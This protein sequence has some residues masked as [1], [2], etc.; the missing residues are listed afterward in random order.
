MFAALERV[1]KYLIRNY[2]LVLQWQSTNFE[3]ELYELKYSF[4]KGTLE[5]VACVT[6]YKAKQKFQTS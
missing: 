6:P 2:N 1:F 5:N 3:N 4:L